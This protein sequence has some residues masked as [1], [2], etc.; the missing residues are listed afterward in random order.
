MLPTKNKKT[1]EV[2]HNVLTASS[3]EYSASLA[4]RGDIVQVTV[5]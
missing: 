5:V 1:N 3:Y 2:Q 4:V